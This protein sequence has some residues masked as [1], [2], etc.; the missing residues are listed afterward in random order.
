MSCE[1]FLGSANRDPSVIKLQDTCNHLSPQSH[2][3]T[4]SVA[5]DV[6]CIPKEKHTLSKVYRND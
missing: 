1:L 4:H 3:H 2:T 6:V 5:V